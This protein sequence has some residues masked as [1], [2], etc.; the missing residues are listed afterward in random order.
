MSNLPPGVTNRMI[1]EYFGGPDPMEY[2]CPK[3]DFV[4]HV[5]DYD[6]NETCPECGTKT[7]VYERDYDEY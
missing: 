7:E 4:M 6:C 1:E 2:W 5:N 3:C